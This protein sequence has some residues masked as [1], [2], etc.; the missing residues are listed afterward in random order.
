MLVVYSLPNC[1]QCTATQRYLS[2]LH[3]PHKTVD[4]SKDEEARRFVASLGHRAAPV[5]VHGEKHWSGFRPDLLKEAV[6][7]QRG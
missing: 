6:G 1:V 7:H 3:A 5:V 4:L 2:K